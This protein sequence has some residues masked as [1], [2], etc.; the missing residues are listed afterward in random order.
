M[1]PG[2]FSCPF[3]ACVEG[4]LPHISV[5]ELMVSPRLFL[6]H[7]YP[8]F[9]AFPNVW[10]L[11]LTLGVVYHTIQT[12]LFSMIFVAPQGAA[13]TSTEAP[14]FPPGKAKERAGTAQVRC[15][16]SLAYGGA[17]VRLL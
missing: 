4:R 2:G 10:L 16:P 15:L 12:V 5:R 11:S 13:G 1:W 14:R 8:Y 7:F 3:Y 9:A 6:S 17:H